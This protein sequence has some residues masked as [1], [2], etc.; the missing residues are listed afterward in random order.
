MRSLAFGIAMTLALGMSGGVAAQGRHDDK[1]HGTA[2]PAPSAPAAQPSVTAADPSSQTIVL[3][4]GTTL[5]VHANGTMYHADAKGNR[6][7]MKDGVVMEGKDGKKYLMKNDA[8]WQAITQKG[9][10]HPSHP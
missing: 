4:D 2:A 7:R 9:T 8:L 6:I 10:L 1:Q 3:K 5:V